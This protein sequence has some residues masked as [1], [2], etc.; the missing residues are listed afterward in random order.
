MTGADAVG[1][2]L[3]V[4]HRFCGPPRSANGGYLA[5]R[6]AA[7]LR[8]HS[9][10][11]AV[12]VTLV[13]PA[14]LG[15]RLHVDIADGVVTLAD[16][17]RSTEFA[18]PVI[19]LAR[20]R[21][22]TLDATPPPRVSYDDAVGAAERYAGR[23]DHPFPTCFVCGPDRAPG[24]GM[25]LQPGGVAR[26]RV[27][28]AWQPDASLADTDTGAGAG[29]GAGAGESVVVASE[30]VWAAMDCPGGWAVDLAGRPMVLGRMTGRVVAVPNISEPCVV[31]GECER[32]E[33]RKAFTTSAAYTAAGELLGWASSVWIAVDPDAVR[34]ASDTMVA[35]DTSRRFR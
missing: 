8:P 28:A 34:P 32:T 16:S 23:D 13:R 33:G 10:D 20:A 9:A 30:F 12:E 19:E 31:V 22:A 27:A 2:G 21:A 17:A 24:D 3:L 35:D 6:L 11:D 5:G 18:T 29:A 15:L 26:G 7:L 1:A 25:R 4:A 14:P